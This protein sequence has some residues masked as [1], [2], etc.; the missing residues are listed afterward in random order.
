MAADN[1]PFMNAYGNITKILN[2]LQDAQTPPRFTYDYLST[3]LGVSGG[4]ASPFIPFAKRIGLLASDG[5][6]TDLYKRFKNPT[7]A[8]PAVEQMM[9]KGY[10]ELYKRNE[11][12]H[13]MDK[14]GLEG[15]VR[16][17]TGLEAKSGTL[18]AIVNSFQALNAFADFG[19]VEEGQQEE[20]KPSET[21]DGDGVGEEVLDTPVRFSYTINLNLPDTSDVAVF[22]AI[23]KSLKENLLR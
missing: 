10:G 21:K 12:V 20:G 3:V 14:K 15:L 19:A 9:R 8:G 5:T 18:R 11:F 4:S 6:P 17:A 13:D 22:N 23:F 2:K 1:P 16:E 7:Q